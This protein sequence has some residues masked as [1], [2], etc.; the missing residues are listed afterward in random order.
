MHRSLKIAIVNP[1]LKPYQPENNIQSQKPISVATTLGEIL[2]QHTLARV[3]FC[4]EI[5]NLYVFEQT[6]LRKKRCSR[7]NIG[8]LEHDISN[9]FKHGNATIAILFDRVDAYGSVIHNMQ[10]PGTPYYR[11]PNPRTSFSQPLFH[12]YLLFISELQ[13]QYA[14]FGLY[15]EGLVIWKAERN[16]LE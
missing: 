3:E 15:A 1:I 5:N 9:S 4:V 6:R 14:S 16:V 2:E 13:L 7:D 12:L 11:R 8:C 10:E